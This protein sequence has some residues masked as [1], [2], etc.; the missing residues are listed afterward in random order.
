MHLG[1]RVGKGEEGETGE[2]L[3]IKKQ[4]RNWSRLKKL[5]G[6]VDPGIP[7]VP[8]NSGVCF[9]SGADEGGRLRGAPTGGRVGRRD[10][11][12]S[13]RFVSSRGTCS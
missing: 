8:Q 4:L 10:G 1:L 13:A 3:L 6:A 11:A 7:V 9:L 12:G 2:K 5:S